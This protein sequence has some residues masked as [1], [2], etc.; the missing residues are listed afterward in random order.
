DPAQ[1]TPGL[2]LDGAHAGCRVDAHSFDAQDNAG[3]GWTVP[4]RTGGTDGA[5]VVTLPGSLHMGPQA[6]SVCQGATIS[7]HLATST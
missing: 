1:G 4:G 5:L 3:A 2:S 6:L 7:V